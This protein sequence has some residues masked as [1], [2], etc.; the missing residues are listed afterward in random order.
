MKIARK[1]KELR[2]LLDLNQAELGKKLGVPQA[3]VSKWENEKQEPDSENTVKLA[4]LAGV[5][6][7]EWLGIAGLGK[8][9]LSPRRIPLV[10]E[11]QAGSWREAVVFD[12][13]EYVESPLPPSFGKLGVQAFRVVGT[14]MDRLYPDGTIVYVAPVSKYRAPETGDRV[15]VIRAN[16]KGLFEATL[17]EYTVGA[18]GKKWLW[19]RSSDP[20]HQAPLPY[21]GDGEDVDVTGIVVAHFMV[22]ALV[23][24]RRRK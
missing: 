8:A 1:I 5:Q 22:E 6:A 13:G 9:T 23:P 18:D 7:D 17:K 16:T 14:S 2:T 15:L 12:D 19:P 4:A 24:K 21:G 20:E 3:T 11:L 10:G